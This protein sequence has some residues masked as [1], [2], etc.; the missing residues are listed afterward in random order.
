MKWR[1]QVY[2]DSADR[3]NNILENVLTHQVAVIIVEKVL[4]IY[5]LFIYLFIF[6]FFFFQSKSVFAFH[7]NCLLG[8]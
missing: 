6:F 1:L 5:L 2:A 7:L 8:R 4:F 3:S